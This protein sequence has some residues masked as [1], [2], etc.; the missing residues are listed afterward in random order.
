M[1]ADGCCVECNHR[2]TF[3]PEE[4][5]DPWDAIVADNERLEIEGKHAFGRYSKW[6]KNKWNKYGLWIGQGE[7]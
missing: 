7:K 4:Y 2:L 1:E 6:N 3:W 5:I